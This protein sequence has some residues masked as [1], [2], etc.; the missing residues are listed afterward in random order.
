M[1]KRYQLCA[2]LLLGLVLC[3]A[4]PLLAQTPFV[5][6]NPTAASTWAQMGNYTVTWTGGHAAW[7]VNVSLV[8][9]ATWLVV[10]LI[11]V[12]IP[13][14]GSVNYTVPALVVPG[15]YLVYVEDVDVTSWIYG[16]HFPILEG[17]VSTETATWS[18][19]KALFK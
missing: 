16:E 1:K 7:S 2:M 11:A 4:S 15:T 5:V 8:D 19:V 6:T 18:Q 3:T 17:S 14:S 12:N 13:N 10:D 9:V